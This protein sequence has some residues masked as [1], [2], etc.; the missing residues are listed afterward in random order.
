M[1][2]HWGSNGP[3]FARSHREAWR[4]FADEVGGQLEWAASGSWI[5]KSERPEAER[6]GASQ[7][8]QAVNRSR[9]ELGVDRRAR[10]CP[11]CGGQLIGWNSSDTR[12][13]QCGHIVYP[14]SPPGAL[15]RASSDFEREGEQKQPEARKTRTP[16]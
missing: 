1:R 3:T 8:V 4:Q 2:V 15:L 13:L 7:A 9:G 14:R 6:V 11:R 16:E 10:L 5:F 12:C